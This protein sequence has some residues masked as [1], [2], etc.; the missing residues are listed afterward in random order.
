MR[1]DGPAAPTE[2]SGAKHTDT[3]ALLHHI[4]QICHRRLG[5][6]RSTQRRI[7]PAVTTP[8]NK[9]E[10]VIDWAEDVASIGDEFDNLVE[11]AGR[12][13]KRQHLSDDEDKELAAAV[14]N[15]EG[16]AQYAKELGRRVKTL[17][18][19]MIASA[20]RHVNK[21]LAKV[22]RLGHIPEE[23]E[24]FRAV[25]EEAKEK[26]RL[27]E[28]FSKYLILSCAW[29]DSADGRLKELSANRAPKQ[30]PTKRPDVKGCA[31][32]EEG[33]LRLVKLRDERLA[34][35]R[36]VEYIDGK[37]HVW[38]PGTVAG[39]SSSGISATFAP[40]PNRYSVLNE[41]D[42][43]KCAGTTQRKVQFS[44]HPDNPTQEEARPSE[45]FKLPPLVRA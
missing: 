36:R 21:L 17:G 41:W 11:K 34:K 29:L 2:E 43:D 14:A 39:R 27:L 42:D 19:E 30:Q 33:F 35:N 26:H 16:A 37:K 31:K 8:A 7:Q 22:D 18:A 25:V 40:T 1:T 32:L 23:T 15:A 4:E 5:A 45:A 6:A 13:G 24:R 10:G 44:G 20:Q 28:R 3:K 9:Y 38:A 12:L